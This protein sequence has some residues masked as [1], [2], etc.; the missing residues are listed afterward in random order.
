MLAL[1]S[2]PVVI[3]C[4]TKAIPCNSCSVSFILINSKLDFA[5]A[6]AGKIEDVTSPES[7][8]THAIN[9]S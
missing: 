9:H 5:N 1:P 6:A 2:P 7:F 8:G 3:Y 4:S